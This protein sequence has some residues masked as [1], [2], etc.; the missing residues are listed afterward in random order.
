M[1]FIAGAVLYLA[2]WLEALDAGKTP[3]SYDNQTVPW[4]R[5]PPLDGFPVAT[6]TGIFCFQKEEVT[7][8]TSIKYK[9]LRTMLGTEQDSKVKG[10]TFQYMT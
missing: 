4:L 2:G 6:D 7:V 9:V 10:Q 8:F 1:I 5:T 3:S